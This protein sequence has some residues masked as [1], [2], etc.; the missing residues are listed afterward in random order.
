MVRAPGHRADE[1]RVGRGQEGAAPF[2]VMMISVNG[3]NEA[4]PNFACSVSVNE[5]CGLLK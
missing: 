3:R 4:I 2:G 1:G 5:I